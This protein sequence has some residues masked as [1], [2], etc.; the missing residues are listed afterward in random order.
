MSIVV[1]VRKAGTA[2]IS[3]DTLTSS[4]DLILPGELKISPSKILKLGNAY[5]GLVGST[6]HMR[7]MASVYERYPDRFDFSSASAVFETFVDLHGLLKEH[8]YVVTEEDDDEQEYESNQLTGLIA[9]PSGIYQFQSYREITEY[10]RFWATGTGTRLALG[11]LDALYDS[12]LSASAIA[13]RAVQAAC[14]FDNSCGE[15]IESFQLRLKTTS[16]PRR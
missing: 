15:P 8:Y 16:R 9:C 3:A 14:R 2:A 6:A 1:A 10:N 4:G 12:K 5:M 11:A 7:V 13:K